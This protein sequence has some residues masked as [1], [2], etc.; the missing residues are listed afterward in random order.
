MLFAFP[1]KPMSAKLDYGFDFKNRLEAGETI[2]SGEVVVASGDVVISSVTVQGTIVKFLAE[3]G[4][5]DRVNRLECKAVTS[6][7]REPVLEAAL[8][9]S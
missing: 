4:S 8:P 2:V 5:D 1:A 7:G 3:G 6:S 9:I